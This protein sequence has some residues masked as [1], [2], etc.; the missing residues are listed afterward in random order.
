MKTFIL[1]LCL[2]P[3]SLFAV[4]EKGLETT[5]KEVI[6]PWYGNL[7][8][9]E[10]KNSRNLTV[11]FVYQV[12]QENTKT[13]VIVPGRS[14]PALKYAELAFDLKD[15]G[16][17]LF[18]L[19]H[20]GQGESDRILSDSNKG[21]VI[22]FGDYVADFRQFMGLVNE[23]K[24]ET[25]KFLI[26]HSMG[27]AITTRFISEEARAFRKAVLIAPMMKLN[28][29]PYNEV[30]ARYYSKLLVTIGKGN[31][32]APGYGPY[33]PEEDLFETNVYTHSE[34]RFNISKHIYLTWPD[35][36]LGGPTTRWVHESLKATKS[37]D[38]LPFETKTILFQAGLD[39]TVVNDR[40]TTF[41]KRKGNFCELIHIP[42]ARHE[43]LMEKDSIRDEVLKKISSFFGI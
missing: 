7:S 33:K 29:K 31:D 39:Q 18:I 19:D 4:P 20:Q 32:Y 43:I 14:E 13:L 28:T 35:L 30:V 8:T 10:F 34:A 1:L 17:D 42:D 11:R 21:H 25:E 5:W 12:K 38:K 26:A 3:L 6:Y 40:Q 36:V 16:V 15:K 27:G 41:C 22:S 24:P 9:G 2:L 37:I 23:I